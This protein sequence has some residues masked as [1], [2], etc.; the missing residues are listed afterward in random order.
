[1]KQFLYGYDT[2]RATG[3]SL[4]KLL[5]GFVTAA[6]I[7]C[8]LTVITQIIRLITIVARNT[9]QLKEVL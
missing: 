1:M 9:H 6:F 2:V 5:T 4:R 7:A 3:Y 8:Q